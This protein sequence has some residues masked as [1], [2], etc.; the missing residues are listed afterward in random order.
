MKKQGKKGR[1]NKYSDLRMA[2]Y[3]PTSENL[4]VCD[5]QWM[6]AAKNWMKNIPANFPKPNVESLWQYG[7]LYSKTIQIKPIKLIP[8]K[9]LLEGLKKN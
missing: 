3:H 1:V 7:K 8:K 2:E 5:K 6:F 9:K 4:S